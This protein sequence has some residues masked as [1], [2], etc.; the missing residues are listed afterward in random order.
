VYKIQ[1]TLNLLPLSTYQDG[2]SF[3]LNDLLSAL[4]ES[5]ELELFNCDVVKD[6]IDFQWGSYAKFLHYF[7][8]AVHL[9]Y[10]LLFM[11][12]TNYIYLDR[13][14]ESRVGL[15]WAMFICLL[16]PLVYDGM[17]FI[18]QGPAEYFSDFW[19]FLD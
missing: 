6:F 3:L 9:L 1:Y 11:I 18:K 8:G 5:D 16:Y 4:G 10:V 15:I 7:G 12:Y 13:Y 17:Q 14:Y 2:E 19:N